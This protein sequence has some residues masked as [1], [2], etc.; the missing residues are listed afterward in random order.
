M[1]LNIF[2]LFSMNNQRENDADRLLKLRRK[3]WWDH[4]YHLLSSTKLTLLLLTDIHTDSEGYQ[5]ISFVKWNGHISSYVYL[6]SF[7]ISK[8]RSALRV[9]IQRNTAHWIMFNAFSAFVCPA[10]YLN[11][12]HSTSPKNI[13]RSLLSTE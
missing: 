8:V 11:F 1:F 3:R 12:N 4:S 6:L 9:S 10:S 5:F 13:E 7:F 2:K